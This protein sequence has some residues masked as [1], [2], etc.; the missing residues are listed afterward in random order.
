MV[1]KIIR[2]YKNLLIFQ[3]KIYILFNKILTEKI[4]IKLKIGIFLKLILLIGT[5]NTPKYKL[6]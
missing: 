5:Y 3:K 6:C 2:I 4:L 1:V